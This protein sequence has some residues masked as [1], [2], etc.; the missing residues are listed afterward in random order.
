MIHEEVDKFMELFPGEGLTFDDV[1]LMTRY[2]DFL[3]GEAC[4]KSQFSRNVSLNVPFV[5]AAMD[6]VTENEMAIAMAMHGGLG[7]IHKNLTEVR[8]AE[9]VR[10]VK[11]HLNGLIEAPVTFDSEMTVSEMRVN[12]KD[13]S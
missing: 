1:S 10:R 6:T 9:E 12:A 3:P 8:Q 5:S 13:A 11:G 4:V 7:V 2:S